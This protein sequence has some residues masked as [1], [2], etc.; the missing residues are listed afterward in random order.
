MIN[1]YAIMLNE[2]RVPYLHLEQAIDYKKENEFNSAER[3]VELINV[4]FDLSNCAE[5]RLIT[6]A[7]DAKCH[8][9]GIFKTSHGA[10]NTTEANP[11]NILFR[12]L[13]CG[14]CTF[15]VCHNHP[16]GDCTASADDL[17]VAHRIKE[18][19]DLLG[20]PMCDFII[21][22]NGTFLSFCDTNCL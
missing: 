7:M 15:A 21:I 22:G 16:S 10:L 18:A 3:I 17:T 5:E 9:I 2:N 14:A 8:V 6:V 19:G 4:C 13:L 11:R 20:I 12:A 1:S